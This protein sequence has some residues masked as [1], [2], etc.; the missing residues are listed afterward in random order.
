MRSKWKKKDLY[1]ASFLQDEYDDDGNK[2]STYSKPEYIG[3]KNIQPLSGQSD[4]AEYGARVTKMQKV[5]LDVNFKIINKNKVKDIDSLSVKELDK[6]AVKSLTLKYGDKKI[7][8]QEN[9]L[10]YLDG[11]SPTNEKIHGDNANYRID[12]VR[13]QNKK[14]AIYFEKLP[15]K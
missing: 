1:I 12:S 6:M 9:D 11:A 10:A 5:L 3:K 13:Y 2:I 14:I 8:I 7:T 15:N 4:I